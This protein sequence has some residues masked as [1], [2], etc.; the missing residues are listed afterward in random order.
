MF[1]FLYP[2]HADPRDLG[3]FPWL[4]VL[5]RHGTPYRCQCCGV[6][7]HPWRPSVFVPDACD[8]GSSR[9]FVRFASWQAERT[10]ALSS[11]C[12]SCAWKLSGRKMVVTRR[13][14]WRFWR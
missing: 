12:V 11:W 1:K 4:E 2:M 10:G 8:D 6:M 7:Q 5:E 9:R 3:L 13:P 14:W